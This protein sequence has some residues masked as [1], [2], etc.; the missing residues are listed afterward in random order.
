VAVS[1]TAATTGNQN[2]LERKLVVNLVTQQKI[3]PSV[4]LEA[5]T[6]ALLDLTT[7]ELKEKSGQISLATARAEMTA[8]SERPGQTD[9]LM[10]TEM[11]HVVQNLEVQTHVILIQ[12]ESVSR[13]PDQ[14][15]LGS[16]EL[17]HLALNEATLI[18]PS[19]QLAPTR[20]VLGNHVLQDQIDQSAQ[21]T[22]GALLLVQTLASMTGTAI[23]TA[24][25]A[26]LEIA[27]G[28]KASSALAIRTQT[29]K[30]SSRTG[31]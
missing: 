20:T 6:I 10:E 31:F 19:A 30:L 1:P 9:L 2:L 7:T 12:E 29:R 27:L 11:I 5:S 28:T 21:E 13:P 17:P 16:Q 15:V 4:L 18:A 14:I 25:T 8:Q 24:R 22:Q 26:F 3:A 23:L